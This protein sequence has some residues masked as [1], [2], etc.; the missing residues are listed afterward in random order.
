MTKKSNL[1][2]TVGVSIKEGYEAKVINEAIKR[3][4]NNPQIKGH[5]HE[6]L[7]RDAINMDIK[8]IIAGRTAQIVKNPTAKTVDIVVKQGGKIVERLQLKD[9][10]KKYY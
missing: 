1:K 8:N 6:I 2:N 3:A 9:S 5:I 4:G 10:M 7:V